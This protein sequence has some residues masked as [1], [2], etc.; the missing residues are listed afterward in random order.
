VSNFDHFVTQWMSTVGV[1]LGSATRSSQ[2]HETGSATAPEIVKLH[3]SRGVAG[4][5]PAEHR[6]VAGRVLARRQAR[7]VDV[8]P[9]STAKAAGDRSHR[10]TVVV[11]SRD[12]DNFD[13]RAESAELDPGR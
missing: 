7:G 10:A 11:S 12:G 3:S 5:G 1:S 8:R 4:V 6:E 13:T 9:A 2:L